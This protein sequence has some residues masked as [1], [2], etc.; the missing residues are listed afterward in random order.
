MKWTS[1]LAARVAAK[2]ETSRATRICRACRANRPQ[3]KY[4][5]GAYTLGT[6]DPNRVG[7]DLVPG[8]FLWMVATDTAPQQIEPGTEI[9]A[10]P[11]VVII[12]RNCGAIYQ[13]AMGSLGISIHEE[14][15]KPLIEMATA[16][17][18]A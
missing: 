6:T 2:L 4:T 3:E 8:F 13:F 14:E 16:G 1:E 10:I 11:S 18:T 12:C 5:V 17:R 7:F 15:R 9:Q